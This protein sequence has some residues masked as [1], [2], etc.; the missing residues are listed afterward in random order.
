MTDP[1]N[2]I[3]RAQEA[4]R[5]QA[6]TGIVKGEKLS[7][8]PDEPADDSVDISEEARERASGRKRKT[9]LE[10]LEDEKG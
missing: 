6:R 9:I 4:G 7:D 2:K 3:S 8:H 10:Y 1:I 5:K